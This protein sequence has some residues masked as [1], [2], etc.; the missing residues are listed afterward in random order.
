M[1]PHCIRH[2]GRHT[3][4]VLQSNQPRAYQVLDSLLEDLTALGQLL[5]GLVSQLSLALQL[6][7][8]RQQ[9]LV[10]A[11][12]HLDLQQHNS[13]LLLLTGRLRV[14]TMYDVI[15]TDDMHDSS[16]NNVGRDV[17]HA[18]RT[19]AQEPLVCLIS[20]LSFLFQPCFHQ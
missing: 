1:L 14:G 5:L 4:T 9:G 13:S 12:H 15:D 6:C 8:L 19:V 20:K 2:A 18:D 11:H 17:F 3:S 7:L 16:H 10:L